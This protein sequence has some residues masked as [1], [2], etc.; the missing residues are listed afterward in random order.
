[1]A[2][3]KLMSVILHQ[4]KP[5]QYSCLKLMLLHILNLFS[6]FLVNLLIICSFCKGFQRSILIF[7]FFCHKL[8]YFIQKVKMLILIKTKCFYFPFVMLIQFTPIIYIIHKTHYF[9]FHIFYFSYF[10][11]VNIFTM[12]NKIIN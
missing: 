10:F 8:F 9:I 3:I 4:K 5:K 1:M 7:S 12:F 11:G 2:R 6:L